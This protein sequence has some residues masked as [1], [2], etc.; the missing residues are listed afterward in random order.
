M[1]AT[2]MRNRYAQGT[3]TSLTSS[4]YDATMLE[5][6]AQCEQIKMHKFDNSYA[7]VIRVF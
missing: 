3:V 7:N 5:V 2:R 1:K 4:S 6:Q